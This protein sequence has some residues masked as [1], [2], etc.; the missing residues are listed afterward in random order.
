MLLFFSIGVFAENSRQNGKKENTN[1]SYSG[2]E[3]QTGEST[4][5]E[6][7]LHTVRMKTVTWRDIYGTVQINPLCLE[8][9]GVQEMQNGG[10]KIV[11]A[12]CLTAT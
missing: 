10:L 11:R 4:S 1:F 2:P 5:Q 3:E 8:L 12:E 6:L 9:Q 7:L